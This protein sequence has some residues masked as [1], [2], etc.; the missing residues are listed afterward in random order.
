MYTTTTY[1]HLYIQ[2]YSAINLANL[3]AARSSNAAI[4]KLH[5][6][7]TSQLLYNLYSVL[8]LLLTFFTSFNYFSLYAAT[9][10]LGIK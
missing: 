10:G 9:T 8:A 6:K 3:S 5:I 7:F 2:A 4:T 1:I